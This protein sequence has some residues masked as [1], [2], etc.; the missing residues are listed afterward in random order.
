MTGV[1]TCALPISRRGDLR[2]R[3]LLSQYLP[4]YGLFMFFSLNSA[5]LP[6]WIAPAL[7]PGIVFTVVSWRELLARQPAWRWGVLAAFIMAGSMTL[8]LHHSEPLHLP[9]AMDPLHRAQ[10][11]EDFGARVQAARVKHRANLLLGDD[12]SIASLLAFYLPDQ[13]TTYM[14]PAPY[15]DSQFTLWP[16]YTVTPE[17]RALYIVGQP[18]IA[19]VAL[20]KQ[21]SRIELVE[22]FWTQHH[23]RPMNHF[24]IYLCTQK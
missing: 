1:Q 23:G 16:A 24:C 10:G 15:G 8:A 22:D 4:I 19:P 6:N 17:T 18:H 2:T 12:Y 3:F 20:Q 9:R 13:P 5:G 11:W 21:F 7:I 14:P